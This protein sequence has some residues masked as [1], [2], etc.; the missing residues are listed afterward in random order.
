MKTNEELAIEI[1]QGNRAAIPVLWEQVRRLYMQ[2][3][4]WYFVNHRERCAACG[5]ELEDVQQQSFFAF[6]R[7]VEEYDPESGSTFLAFVDYPFRTEMQVLTNT[8]TKAGRL[9]PLNDCESLDREIDTGDGTGDTLHEI[10]ADSSSL[11]FV[12][13]IDA[14]SVAEMIRHEVNALPDRLRDVV[15]LHDLEGL[16]FTRIADQLGVSFERVRQLRR[17]GISALSR[18]RVLVELWNEMHHTARLRSF[19]NRTRHYNPENY[20]SVK[21]YDAIT[22]PKSRDKL[23]YAFL[24]ADTLRQEQGKSEEEWTREDKIAAIVY[25]LT[26]CSAPQP[27]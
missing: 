23:Y 18:R 21:E 27:A 13:M 26:N 8:R 10:I 3:A 14:Q 6:L 19:E 12:E 20:G 17:Q 16:P 2:K 24:Y 7:S 22:A 15:T 4:F 25:Y 5:V 1:Q 11:D 9:D